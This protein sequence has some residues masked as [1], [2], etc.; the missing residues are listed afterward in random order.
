MKAL[1]SG[2]VIKEHS[3]LSKWT[4]GT[5]VKF[6]E[7]DNEITKLWISEDQSRQGENLSNRLTGSGNGSFSSGQV[8]ETQ[9]GDLKLENGV[10]T[11]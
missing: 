6:F 2:Q 8:S 1:S 10:W 11:N 4:P 3:L 5:A 9:E 7:V